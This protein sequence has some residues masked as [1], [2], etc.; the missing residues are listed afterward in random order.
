MLFNP[1]STASRLSLLLVALTTGGFGCLGSGSSPEEVD[2]GHDES[3]AC[4]GSPEWQEGQWYDEGAIVN[5]QGSAYIAEHGNPGY[6]PT[7]STYFWEPYTACSDAPGPGPGPVGALPEKVV[8]GYYPNWTPA[9]IRI[10]DINSN[11]NLIYLFHAKP[12]GGSPGT[13]GAVFWEPPGDGR[14]AAT[15]LNADIQYARTV[16]GRKIILSVGGARNGMSFPTREKSQTFVDSVVDIYNSLGGFDGLDWNTF[17]ADQDPDTDEM[18]WISLELKRRFPG[19]IITAPPAPWNNRDKTFCKAMVDAGAM[20]YAAPQYYDGPD[21]DQQSYI[22]DNVDGW[23]SLLGPTHVVVGFGIWD[24][25]N[26]MS[27][28]EAIPTWNQL[29][30]EHPTLR[31][32]FDWQIHIDES[33]GWPFADRIGPLVTD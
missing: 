13:T 10:R 21:L 7:V 31:G 27:I 9:P 4:A 12:V 33:L 11:Y 19:F 18:I 3:A 28:D 25:V 26:Y 32:A 16:Q 14:G 2:V 8:A 17:E 22:V 6:I 30:S 1:K 15:N 24:E 23:V 29:E 20:D 5:Y